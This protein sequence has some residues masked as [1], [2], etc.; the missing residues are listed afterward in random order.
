[1]TSRAYLSFAERRAL[2]ILVEGLIPKLGT[3]GFMHGSAE[4]D[5]RKHLARVQVARQ[6]EKGLPIRPSALASHD[7]KREYSALVSQARTTAHFDQEAAATKAAK[8]ARVAANRGLPPP[9]A[10]AAA[11][12]ATAVTQAAP[13]AVRRPRVASNRFLSRSSS[14]SGTSR[15]PF[16]PKKDSSKVPST[17]IVK[18][19]TDVEDSDMEWARCGVCKDI[20]SGACEGKPGSWTF[21]GMTAE[22]SF[23]E[24]VERLKR[25]G[26]FVEGLGG[27]K[28]HY[29]YGRPCSCPG[30]SGISAGECC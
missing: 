27:H 10:A 6:L 9:S 21:Q 3:D 29:C 15:K 2:G 23:R 22:E 16:S 4:S 19:E 26:D 24:N 18:E 11:V 14:V 25:N 13:L 30:P 8:T 7:I 17:S 1:M 28:T 20:H 5:R 12:L